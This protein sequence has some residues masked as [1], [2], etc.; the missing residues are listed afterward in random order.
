[1]EKLA[2]EPIFESWNGQMMRPTT[3]VYIPE[4]FRDN[5]D[6]PLAMTTDKNLVL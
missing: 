6:T 4:L 5:A 3:L 1:L 2:K